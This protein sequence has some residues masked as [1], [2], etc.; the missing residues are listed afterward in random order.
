ME[1]FTK[2]ALWSARFKLVRAEEHLDSIAKILRSFAY[3][4]CQLVPEKDAKRNAIFLRVCLP[5]PPDSLPSVIGDFLFNVRSAL[6]HIVYSL[7]SR[8]APK[9]LRNS[10]AFPICSSAD[11]FAD[12]LKRRLAGVPEKAVTLIER[13]QPY[14]GGENPLGTL[15]NLHNIDKHRS[16]HLATAVASAV[17]VQWR[18]EQ[19]PIVATY[20]GDDELRDGAQFGDIE[21]RLDDSIAL[22][23]HDEVKVQGK[24]A[25]F[26]AFDNPTAESLE[27]HRVDAVLQSIFEFVRYTVFEAFEPF[28]N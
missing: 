11:N 18:D 20:L 12:A 27:P 2:P 24:A 3:G 9:E 13:L 4:D 8:N 19:D 25:I 17:A 23:L 16:L 6:D 10:T 5:K 1:P 15:D 22:R 14:H 21:M 28:F 7:I 26:V